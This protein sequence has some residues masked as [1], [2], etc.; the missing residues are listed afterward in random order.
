MQRVQYLKCLKDLNFKYFNVL[1]TNIVFCLLKKFKNIFKKR[2]QK[3]NIL[4]YLKIK[5]LFY[6]YN[7][8][9]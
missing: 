4:I 3:Q 9:I 2:R 5:H 8:N 7:N 6:E 1:N